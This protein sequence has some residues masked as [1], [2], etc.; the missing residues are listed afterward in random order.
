MT[1]YKF[2]EAATEADLRQMSAVY[3]DAERRHRQQMDKTWP[4]LVT[5]VA[6]GYVLAMLVGTE[7]G[8]RLLAGLGVIA[9]PFSA[10]AWWQQRRQRDEETRLIVAVENW[11]RTHG[12]RVRPGG[13]YEKATI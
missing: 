7:G 6:G 8:S 3:T 10:Y 13:S 4:M 11:F 5:I 12:Y 1:T 9:L 2:P